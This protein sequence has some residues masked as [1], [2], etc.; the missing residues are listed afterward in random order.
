MHN[1]TSFVRQPGL[2]SPLCFHGLTNCFSGKP[3][4]VR[5]ICVAPRGVP[6]VF[7]NPAIGRACDFAWSN[8]FSNL[9]TLLRSWCSFS[10]RVPL[11]SAAYRLFCKI[12]GGGVVSVDEGATVDALLVDGDAC[13]IAGPAAAEH[14]AANHHSKGSVLRHKTRG[15]HRRAASDLAPSI[16]D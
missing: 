12:P 14:C 15:W 7:P 10:T 13:G 9:R 6:Y 4:V 3:F 2:L 8:V 11:F 16:A 5:E 1:T